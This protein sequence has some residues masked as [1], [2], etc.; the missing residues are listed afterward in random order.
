MGAEKDQAERAREQKA[1]NDAQV[2][3]DA[4]SLDAN[5]E[6]ARKSIADQSAKEHAKAE[7]D[8]AERAREQ[9]ARND[10]QV[11]RDAKSLDANVEAA[12]K[13]K[14]DQSAQEHADQA[15]KIHE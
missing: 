5:V 10:A 2:G 12:R 1:R 9:K 13:S 15:K 14:A 4:K 8:Q 11:G 7:K 6:A 3:R